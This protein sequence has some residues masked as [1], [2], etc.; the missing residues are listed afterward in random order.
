MGLGDWIMAS[1]EVKQAHI[2]T[3]KKVKLGDG[4]RMF[5][6]ANVFAYNPRMA[7]KEDTNVTW[8]AN[9]PS[10]RPYIA[11][12]D[13]K[14]II[15]NDDYRPLRGEIYLSSDEILWAKRSVPTKDYILVEP[16]V[17]KTYVHTVNKSWPHFDELVKADLPFIQ[18][19]EPDARRITNFVK[20]MSFRQALAVL[21]NAKLFIGTDGALHHAAAALGIPSVVI[22]TGF[23]SPK[24]L[25]YDTQVNIH[26]GG[27]PCGHYAGVCQHC[28]KIAKSISP[29]Q[30]LEAVERE[31]NRIDTVRRG[32]A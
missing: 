7:A 5:T 13:G 3:G 2:A 22:W 27:E 16:N 12:N 6:D 31:I 15:F 4:N 11:G 18:V 29:E 28:L 32:E 9:Y 25:G 14:R 24:H 10:K 30:V 26:D 17:K 20:T 21:S 1:G 19:G 8:V 23:T